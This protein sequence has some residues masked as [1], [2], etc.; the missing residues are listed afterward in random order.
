[1]KALRYAAFTYGSRLPLRFF[2][3]EAHR[4]YI[5]RA[6]SQSPHHMGTAAG[7]VTAPDRRPGRHSDWVAGEDGGS[8]RIRSKRRWTGDVVSLELTR[9]RRRNSGQ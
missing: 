6:R 4:R 2:Q 8:R 5:G 9:C 7:F 3:L 1:M